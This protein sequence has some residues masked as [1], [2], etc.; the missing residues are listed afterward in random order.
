MTTLDMNNDPG[1]F[2]TQSYDATTHFET[3]V[4]DVLAL[5]TAITGKVDNN[6]HTYA[7]TH[8]HTDT[9]THALTHTHM[10]YVETKGGKVSYLY[11][12]APTIHISS[13]SYT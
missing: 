1:Y 9:C 2:W 5:Y 11:V 7:H 12:H 10:L 4:E 8:A 3:T 6:T 13:P